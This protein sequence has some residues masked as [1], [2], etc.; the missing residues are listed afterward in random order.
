MSFGLTGAPATF[1][2]FMNFVLAALLRKCVV[3]FIDDVLVYSKS[4]E[5]HVQHL[6]MVFELLHQHQLHLKLSKC[7]FA[8]SQLE[9]LGHII[10]AGGVS[11]DPVKVQIV[12]RWPIPTCGK[13]VRSFLGWQDTI[14]DLCKTL[15]S[16]AGH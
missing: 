8:K 15:A 14:G 1:Q 9:F 2:G 4:M 16:P 5:E 7:S 6:K 10:S 13:D 12:Q 11:T 3:V